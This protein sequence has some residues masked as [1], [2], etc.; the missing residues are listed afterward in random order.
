MITKDSY[1]TYDPLDEAERKIALLEDHI[2]QLKKDITHE[3][4]MKNSYVN[5]IER[6]TKK[7]KAG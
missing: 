6:M 3:R 5:Q 2:E 1:E 7:R 4:S